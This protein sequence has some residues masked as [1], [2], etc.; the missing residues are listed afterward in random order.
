MSKITGTVAFIGGVLLIIMAITGIFIKN[1]RQVASSHEVV[2][3]VVVDTETE[4]EGG[5]SIPQWLSIAMYTTLIISGAFT[6]IQVGRFGLSTEPSAMSTAAF[7]G[8]MVLVGLG[9]VATL[10]VNEQNFRDQQE[11]SVTIKVEEEIVENHDADGHGSSIPD[12]LRY[13]MMATL[14][15]SGSIATIHVTKY[16]LA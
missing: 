10:A 7:V 11:A 8:G 2:T 5:H 13:F 12:E 14:F 4:H 6:I 16:G 3:E 9:F 1:E 15:I